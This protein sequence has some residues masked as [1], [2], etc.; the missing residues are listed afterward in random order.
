MFK[1]NKKTNIDFLIL[2]FIMLELVAG[3][4]FAYSYFRRNENPVKAEVTGIFLDSISTLS[5]NTFIYD[6]DVAPDG[7]IYNTGTFLGTVDFDD[8]SGVDN[9]TS[10]GGSDIFIRKYNSN[11][12][13]AWTKRIGGTSY[14]YVNSMAVASD[15]NIFLGGAFFGTVDFDAGAGTDN[16]TAASSSDSFITKYD[17]SGNF[18]WAKTLSSSSSASANGLSI[19][20]DNYLYITGFFKGNA[21]FDPGV[22]TDIKTAVSTGNGDSYIQKLDL[23]GVYVWSRAFGGTNAQG[24]YANKLDV[25]TNGVYATGKFAGTVDFDGTGGTDNK[26]STGTSDMFV[27]RYNTD[28]SYGWTKIYLAANNV[29]PNSIKLDSLGNIY[30]GGYFYNS[31]I[32]FDDGVGTDNKSSSG[33]EG[34]FLK[35]NSAGTYQWSRVI[36]S[37]AY[38]NY[39]YDLDFDSSNN[40]YI[41]GESQKP[42]SNAPGAQDYTFYFAQYNPSGTLQWSKSFI[43]NYSTGQFSAI[44]LRND[45]DIFL[46]GTYYGSTDFDDTGDFATIDVGV[47]NNSAV[48][49]KYSIGSRYQISGLDAALDA[50]KRIT[51]ADYYWLNVETS[52]PDGVKG[53]SVPLAITKGTSAIA[54]VSTDMSSQDRNWSNITADTDSTTVPKSFLSTGG[55]QV[56]GAVGGVYSLL[57]PVGSRTKVHVCPGASS[58]SAVSVDCASGA[59]YDTGSPGVTQLTY[60]SVSYWKIDGLSGSNGLISHTPNQIFNLNSSLSAKKFDSGVIGNGIKL[61]DT[62]GATSTTQDVAITNASGTIIAGLNLNMSADRDWSNVSAGTDGTNLKS[63]FHVSNGYNNLPG[64]NGPFDLY[65]AQPAAESPETLISAGSNLWGNNIAVG[66]NGK[67]YVTYYKLNSSNNSYE[68]YFK[69]FNNANDFADGNAVSTARIDE[70]VNAGGSNDPSLTVLPNGKVFVVWTEYQAPDYKYNIIGK[71]FDADGTALG[72]A[73]V[74][75][76]SADSSKGEAKAVSDSSNKVLVV[77]ED[78]INS[79]AQREVVGQFI[80]SSMALSGGYFSISAQRIS[81]PA[82]AVL[83]NNKFVV[84][85]YDSTEETVRARVLNNDGS[86][87]ATSFR[88]NSLGV[89]YGGSS[90]NYAGYYQNV[91]AGLNGEFAIVWGGYF[92]DNVNYYDRAYIQVFNSNYTKKITNESDTVISDDTN[93][94]DWDNMNAVINSAGKYLMVWDTYNGSTNLRVYARYI[95]TDGTFDGA[96]KRV[97]DSTIT[98]SAC[99][100]SV[101]M[102][103]DDQ[104][105]FIWDPRLI[106]DNTRRV[107]GKKWS[108]LQ[109]VTAQNIGIC[110]NATSLSEVN[111]ACS[112]VSFTPIGDIPIVTIGGRDYY[113]IAG[114]TGAGAF[115]GDPGAPTPTETPTPTATST[116]TPTATDT[117]TPTPGGPTSTPTP[118]SVEPTAT[119]SPTPPSN[120]GQDTLPTATPTTAPLVVH[121]KKARR[122]GKALHPGPGAAGNDVDGEEGGNDIPS[123]KILEPNGSDDEAVEKYTIYWTD[124]DENDNAKIGFYFDNDKLGR[125]GT[126]IVSGILEDDNT[127]KYEWDISKLE[128]GSYYVYAVIDDSISTPVAVYS[129]GPLTKLP[130]QKS[131]DIINNDENL[132]NDDTDCDGMSDIWENANGFNP[133]DPKDAGKDADGDGIT[134]LEEFLRNTNPHDK[135]S[136]LPET[137]ST[138]GFPLN[139]VVV[140][141]AVIFTVGLVGFIFWKIK[142]NKTSNL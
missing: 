104:A 34:F 7:S 86:F 8:S 115:V 11:G 117:P 90:N 69:V 66:S 135:S 83:S 127:D 39:I 116:P 118:T 3:G 107:V 97:D 130:D 54:Y 40:V 100:P 138:E 129:L 33:Y 114:L 142:R 27:T 58:L 49:A 70:K 136:S 13:Y 123:I 72:A 65:I 38:A 20:S 29:D 63:F 73:F 79:G 23:D 24:T 126:L 84:T 77:W 101:A 5:A 46:A 64:Q 108:T 89:N 105:L 109:P 56:A 95:N 110:P 88:V 48:F 120:G 81:E 137:G 111:N 22:G 35:Y 41:S 132:E 131:C 125:D 82:V 1:L 31:T 91:V 85:W 92:D 17:S 47:N 53:D 57:V 106:V 74:I 37:S 16:H 94:W 68:V 62:T 18:V 12:S 36:A 76:P 14:D 52:A 78:N 55:G 140:A 9:K 99:C 25:D 45:T 28:G 128:V 43:N 59:D 19:S 141:G 51:G 121:H 113:K 21:D 15:G 96:A 134:N 80:D 4:V 75:N 119:P 2:V 30:V 102:T 98:K 124:E 10:S 87:V 71:Y 61:E 139:A 112:G 103:P 122:A 133:N 44:V 60:N 50:K 67:V 42:S 93:Q 26:V 6:M 32:D